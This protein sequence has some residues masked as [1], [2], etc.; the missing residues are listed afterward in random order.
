MKAFL[1]ALL[2]AASA[3]AQPVVGPEVRSA[4][5]EAFGDVALLPE[6]DGYVIASS[7]GHQI[8]IGRLDATLHQ[9]E[10]L[11]AVPLSASSAIAPFVT[12]A[13]TGRSILLVWKEQ[14]PGY[15]ESTY[16]ATL[17]GD[18]RSLLA[19]P[20]FINVSSY[21]PAAGVRNGRYVLVSGDESLLLTDELETESIQA[22]SAPLS[23]AVSSRGEAATVTVVVNKSY[24]CRGICPF[25]PPVSCSTLETFTFNTPAVNRNVQIA[26]GPTVDFSV[27]PAHDPIVAVDGDHF[28][29]V[30][31]RNLETDVFEILADGGGKG[32]TLEPLPNAAQIA[33]AGN[34]SEVLVV[35]WSPPALKGAILR[36]DRTT[37]EPFVIAETYSA[38]KVLVANSNELVVTY[39]YDID[40]QHSEIAGRVI[41]LQPSKHRAIR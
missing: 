41:R 25:C 10:A 35:W 27:P 18:A 11:L 34:G 8:S 33:A 22:I 23:A 4:P 29:G 38:P 26:Y 1:F 3:A 30:V 24:F 5:I 2:L 16:A 28:I 39:R 7:Q 12:L 37:S 40:A 21:A 6:A 31:P 9:T 19:S 20:R 13:T 32:W 36:A 14:R 15:A 17:T